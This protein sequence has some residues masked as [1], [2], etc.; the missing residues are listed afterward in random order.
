M[1]RGKAARIK[2]EN[3]FRWKVKKAKGEAC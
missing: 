1:R 3:T 2:K